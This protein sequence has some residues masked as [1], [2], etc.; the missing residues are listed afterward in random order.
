MKHLMTEARGQFWFAP[1]KGGTS[2]TW[3]YTFQAKNRLAKLP[4]MLFVK[5]QWKGYMD[6]CLKNIIV[7]MT[8]RIAADRRRYYAR[9]K[10]G[11]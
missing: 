6:A 11:K 7:A 10:S 2:V 5:T 8:R 3:T 9:A 1:A 4:L